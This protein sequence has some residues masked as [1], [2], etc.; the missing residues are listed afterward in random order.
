MQRLT[1]VPPDNALPKHRLPVHERHSPPDNTL[2]ADSQIQ[3]LVQ[4]ESATILS[5]PRN[6]EAM[7]DRCFGEAAACEITVA[8]VGFC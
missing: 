8:A 7:E 1:S 5:Q 3:A 2:A 6:S 4:V